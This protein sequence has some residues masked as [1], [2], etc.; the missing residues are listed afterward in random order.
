M[1][2]AIPQHAGAAS[3]INNAAAR[4]AGVLAIAVFGTVLVHAF[5]LRLDRKL[6]NLNLP[7]GVLS[8]LRATEGELRKMDPPQGLDANSASQVRDAIAD[9]FSFA[10]CTVLLCCAALSF[11]GA[12]VASSLIAGPSFK[13]PTQSQEKREV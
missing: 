5:D 9:S 11:A 10:F 2:S 4:V 1:N 13:A 12:A 6:T 7:T 3:G 8:E